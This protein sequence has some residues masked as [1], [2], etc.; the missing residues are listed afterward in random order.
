MDKGCDQ[1]LDEETTLLGCQ[2][3]FGPYREGINTEALGTVLEK[4]KMT[5]DL[6][7]AGISPAQLVF[8]FCMFCTSSI[9]KPKSDHFESIYLISGKEETCENLHVDSPILALSRHKITSC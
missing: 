8:F 6:R 2:W 4:H 3:K 9:K 1:R 7:M 5:G